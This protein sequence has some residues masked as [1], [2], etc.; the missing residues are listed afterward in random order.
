MSAQAL[1]FVQGYRHYD[2]SIQAVPSF[3][4]RFEAEHL[5]DEFSRPQ[6]PAT[7]HIVIAHRTDYPASLHNDF[8]ALFS[9]VL[10]N[11]Y[12]S[13]PMIIFFSNQQ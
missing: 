5:V 9:L 7:L 6:V 8:D 13:F 2:L 10:H 3:R 4:D 12:V 11:Q 1:R